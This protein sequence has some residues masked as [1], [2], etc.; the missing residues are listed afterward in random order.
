MEQDLTLRAVPHRQLHYGARPHSESCTTPRSG[1]GC[2]LEGEWHILV[3]TVQGNLAHIRLVRP[4]VFSGAQ[5][6]IMVL[7]YKLND[8]LITNVIDWRM[9]ANYI[10]WL[11]NYIKT[12]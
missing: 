4:C 10:K 11:T 12:L 5:R 8:L 7:T 1:G 2:A 6:F 9:Q 3:F